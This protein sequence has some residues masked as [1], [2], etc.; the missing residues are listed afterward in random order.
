MDTITARQRT[1]RKKKDFEKRLIQLGKMEETLSKKRSSLGWEPLDPPVMRGWRRRFVL[2]EDTAASPR[3]A[4]FEGILQ[5]INTI[6]YS[7][8]KSWKEKS[9]G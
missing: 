1:R 8:T 3:A 9:T 4:F 7:G 5:K 2:R 6:Q